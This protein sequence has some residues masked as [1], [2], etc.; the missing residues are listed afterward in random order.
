MASAMRNGPRFSLGVVRSGTIVNLRQ[1]VS[2]Q[3]L[4]ISFARMNGWERRTLTFSAGESVRLSFQSRLSAGSLI[5]ELIAPDGSVAIRWG[6]SPNAT[7]D[8]VAP[9]PG[10]Y[11]L[12]ATASKAAGGYKVEIGTG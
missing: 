7:E 11:T 4:E 10:K 6:D 8:F 3:V 2:P 5:V 12:K 9:L 1:R